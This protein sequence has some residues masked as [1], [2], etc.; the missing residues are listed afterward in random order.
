MTPVPALGPRMSSVF[1]LLCPI[2]SFK[3]VEEIATMSIDLLSA[4]KQVRNPC[5][6]EQNIQIRIGIHSGKETMF[7]YT[8]TK[9]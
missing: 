8:K 1:L 7:I 6:P 9:F 2:L 3:H 4:I 5:H